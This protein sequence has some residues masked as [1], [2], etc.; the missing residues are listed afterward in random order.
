VFRRFFAL[1][2]AERAFVVRAWVSLALV[3]A[4][5]RVRGYARTTEWLARHEARGPTRRCD[6]SPARIARLVEASS[7]F[8]P[9]GRHCLSRSAALA[10]L[11]RRR[12]HAATIEFGVARGDLGG[13]DAHAWVVCDG[14]VL[15]GGCDLDRFVTLSGATTQRGDDRV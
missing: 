10:T 8:V 3:R 12:G 1:S 14:E 11:L 7:H 2:M 4:S 15:L 13:L 5:V 6:L 9:D